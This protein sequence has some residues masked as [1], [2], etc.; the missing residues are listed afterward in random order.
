MPLR[1]GGT[2][3]TRAT[4]GGA[5]WHRRDYRRSAAACPSRTSTSRKPASLPISSQTPTETRASPGPDDD[6]HLVREV[7][8]RRL[9]ERPR[10]GSRTARAAASRPPRSAVGRGRR[11]EDRECA[12]LPARRRRRRERADRDADP[13]RRRRLLLR[14]LDGRRR[15]ATV[16]GASRG[17]GRKRFDRTRASTCSSRACARATARRA[18]T[19]SAGLRTVY[20]HRLRRA[21]L[22]GRRGDTERVRRLDVR[23]RCAPRGPGPRAS[24]ARTPARAVGERLERDASL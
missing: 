4:R 10:A 14:R 13:E 7:P 11:D 9:L 3:P 15:R 20:V 2:G 19:V 5:A 8:R 12:A 17:S 6:G 1:Q 18:L 16:R 21:R 22:A 23:R 24:R